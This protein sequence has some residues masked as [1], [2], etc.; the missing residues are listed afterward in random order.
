M[1]WSCDLTMAGTYGVLTD[2]GSKVIKGVIS[3][4]KAKNSAKYS[5]NHC[6]YILH[7]RVT[8]LAH[9]HYYYSSFTNREAVRASLLP[10]VLFHC[11]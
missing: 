5:K 4:L 10:V 6:L 7:S 8:S 9:M 1:V 2:K 11:S 3:G